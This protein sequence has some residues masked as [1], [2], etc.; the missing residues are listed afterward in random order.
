MKASRK[1]ACLHRSSLLTCH[2]TGQYGQ[3][4]YTLQSSF[5][6]GRPPKSV[7][8]HW[9][10]FRIS[11]I[12]L[13]NDKAFEVW[14]R[15]RWKEKDHYLDYYQRTGHFPSTD[16]WKASS[17]AEIFKIKPAKSLEAQVKSSSWGEFLAIFAPITAFLTVLFLFY[18]A[19]VKEVLGT[20]ASN[21]NRRV[22]Q[23]QQKGQLQD[24][25][26]PMS[27]AKKALKNAQAANPA[28]SEA[29]GTSAGK[30]QYGEWDAIRKAL[31]QKNMEGVK[32][33]APKAPSTVD[34][35][36]GHRSFSQP[37][38]KAATSTT[39]SSTPAKARKPL[40]VDESNDAL[41]ALLAKNLGQAQNRKQLAQQTIK[42][43][44]GK[45]MMANIPEV[46]EAKKDGPVKL[47]NGLTIGGKKEPTPPG[48]VKL[49]NG[50]TVG[51]KKE[52]TPPTPVKLANGVT[53][54]GK[55]P[56]SPAPT[57]VRKPSDV[58][59]PIPLK[60]SPPKKAA[61]A[62]P[63]TVLPKDKKPAAGTASTPSLV[64]SGPTRSATTFSTPAPSAAK[65]PPLKKTSAQPP[66]K[67][68]ASGGTAQ[69]KSQNTGQKASAAAKPAAKNT[70]TLRPLVVQEARGPK[71]KVPVRKLETMQKRKEGS[72]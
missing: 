42:L 45:V 5:F 49:A 19:S 56:S 30:P 37:T 17:P 57:G 54:G 16:P 48:P 65:A 9:R 36:S 47:A 68:P 51:G 41:T 26:L 25:A 27:L 6:E 46:T 69:T 7:N 23:A 53:I 29:S 3:D 62:L 72:K 24:G 40:K 4:I 18:G 15:N 67:L 8:M 32:S 20:G 59:K 12:P 1:S 31:A 55:G 21:A 10:R 11:S 61:P 14:M 2:R 13:H 38:R 35:V 63:S 43:A 28:A 50:V 66:K 60:K 64:N 58:A 71:E 70:G 33:F 52:A 34:S 44:N 22:K 39:E